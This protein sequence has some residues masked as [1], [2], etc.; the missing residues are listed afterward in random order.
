M[1][2]DSQKFPTPA[3]MQDDIASRGRKMVVIIDPHVKRDSGFEMHTEAQ[4]K[5][6]YVRDKDNS[7]FEGSVAV[8][9]TPLASRSSRVWG[10]ALHCCR[11]ALDGQS[12]VVKPDSH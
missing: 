2:W 1:T 5:G 9:S 10:G 11:I 3:R 6:Y 12:S 8:P 7:T 4:E